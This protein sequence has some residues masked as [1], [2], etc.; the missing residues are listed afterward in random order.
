MWI[1]SVTYTATHSNA[2]SLTHLERPGI[3]PASSQ[4][5]CRSLTQTKPQWERQK[6][7][8][9]S[10]FLKGVVMFLNYHLRLWLLEVSVS[11]G[12]WTLPASR[13]IA[14]WLWNPSLKFLSIYH[15]SSEFIIK[16]YAKI[17][18]TKK[19]GFKNQMI[20]FVRIFIVLQ[21]NCLLSVMWQ[22]LF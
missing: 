4:R 21:I 3:K 22:F 12:L 19:S 15:L 14:S 8:L 7:F 16:F 10:T 6:G 18:N 17:R 20:Y 11:Q 5:Q 13:Q 1:R 2:G 9:P